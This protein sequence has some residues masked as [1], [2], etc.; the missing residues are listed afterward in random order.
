MFK[1]SLTVSKIYNKK[2][3]S[4]HMYLCITAVPDGH[5]FGCSSGQNI[6]VLIS[7]SLIITASPMLLITQH[8]LRY[9]DSPHDPVLVQLVDIQ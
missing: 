6:Y 7:G 2:K 3:Y 8:T 9:R 4:L 1:P 5:I